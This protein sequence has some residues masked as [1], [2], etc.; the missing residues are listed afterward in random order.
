MERPA[1]Y[2]WLNTVSTYTHKWKG[3]PNFVAGS[4]EVGYGA[5]A[6]PLVIGAVFGAADWVIEGLNDSKKLSACALCR[7]EEA[8]YVQE[9]LGHIRTSL[10]FIHPKDIDA[11]GVMTAQRVAHCR[12]L[13][14]VA[15]GRSCLLIVDGA[16]DLPGDEICVPK[17]D[18][19]VPHVMAASIIAK[20]ARD[21]FMVD[22]AVDYPQ[23]GFEKHVGYGVPVHQQAIASFGLS[24]VHRKSYKLRSA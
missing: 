16:L 3:F 12:A 7:M 24:D 4:D 9:R 15:G 8:I 17:A 21:R 11:F 2:N 19:F 5:L 20:T 6:G 13:E 18:T 22:L 10:C 14:V 23:Y 1:H